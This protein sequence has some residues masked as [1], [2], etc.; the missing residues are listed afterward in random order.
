[1][2][3]ILILV[4]LNHLNAKHYKTLTFAIIVLVDFEEKTYNTIFVYVSEVNFEVDS[5]FKVIGES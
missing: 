1:M 4:S 5:K 3:M 2:S